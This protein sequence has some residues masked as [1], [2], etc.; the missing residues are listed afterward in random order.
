[1][2]YIKEKTIIKGKIKLINYLPDIGISKVREEI[3]TGLKAFPKYISSKFFYDER[4]SELFEAITKLNEYYPTRIEKK[5]I[6]TIGK[7]LNL[8]F[9]ELSIIE[10]GSGDSSKIRLLLRQIQ[11]NKLSTIKYF[12]VDISQSA[13]EMATEKLADEFPMIKIQGIV[14]DFIYQ[15]NLIPK[16]EKRLFC[17]FGST[18]GNLNMAEIEQF[19]KLLGEE[20]QE[21]DSF[22]LGMDMVKDI[23]VLEKAYNDDQQITADF[24]KNILN[25][26]NNLVDTNF[27]LAEFEHLAFYNLEKNRIEMHLK[28]R[29]DIVITFNSAAGKIYIK[30]GETIHT[31]NSH[32]F[33]YDN[34]KSIGYWAGLDTEKIFTDNNKWFSLVHYKKNK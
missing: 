3:Y 23:A 29:K 20:M 9:P 32:K 2:D 14:A 31:E 16:S 22:L 1:M 8:D 13:I 34:I 4:G 26:I 21:G 28:A 18:I 5:I 25:V 15:H 6:S 7:G 33:N 24:N 10:L 11:K 19:M 27:K 30:K 17:F 12:P